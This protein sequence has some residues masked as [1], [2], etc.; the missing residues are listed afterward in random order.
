[1]LI[2]KR[3]VGQRVLITTPDGLRIEISVDNIREKH[4]SL[5]FDAPRNV[6]ILRQELE[7]PQASPHA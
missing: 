4:V 1:M 5:K 7:I 2:L 3:K 6:H